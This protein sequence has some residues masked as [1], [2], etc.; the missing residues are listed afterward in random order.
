[1]SRDN[2]KYLKQ[3]CFQVGSAA[4]AI[5]AE[6]VR[7][8]G[9]VGELALATLDAVRH[10]RKVKWRTTFYYM[11]ACGSDAVPIIS[12]LGLLV[13]VILAFQAIV[14]L[15]RYGVESYVINLVGTVIVSELGPLIT[16]IVLAG[17]SGSAFAAE[18]GVMKAGEEL[19]AMV[20]M[21]LPT[22]RHLI[23]PKVLALLVVNPGL[24]IIANICGIVGGMLV[25]CSKLDFTLTEYYFKVIEVVQPLDLFQGLFKSLFFAIII[26]SVGCMKGFDSSRDA[27]GVGRAATSAVVTAIFLIILT[28]AALTA[29]FS[30]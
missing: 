16:A 17:R 13:G 26:A 29:L 30:V 21:G 27:Q 5:C 11:D 24:T 10:P 12:L 1:M 20:T 6:M 22:S 14:Q 15:G 2:D 19:D 18:I 9:F 25:V 4:C 8:A 3:L 7:L 28:D 23:I